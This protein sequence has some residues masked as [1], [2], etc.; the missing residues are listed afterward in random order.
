MDILELVPVF[1]DVFGEEAEAAFFA[2]GRVNLIGEHLDYNGG[3]VF[4]CALTLGT[5][6]LLRRRSDQTVRCYSKNFP[7]AGVKTFSLSDNRYQ[8]G[9][10]WANVVLGLLV[11]LP[12]VEGELTGFDLFIWGNLPHQA[13]LSSSAALELLVGT[14]LNETFHLGLDRL[15]LVKLGQR[16][17][18]HFLGVNSGIMDQF[19]V[20]FGQKDQALYLD[21]ASLAYELVPTHFA[22]YRLLIMDSHK[23][24]EL[25][26]SAYNDRREECEGALKALQEVVD[27][28]HLCE[29]TP[30]EFR[31]HQAVIPTGVMRQRARH[32]VMEEARTQ[33]AKKA[34]VAGDLARFGEL[35]NESHISLRDDYDITGPELDCLVDE[36]QRHFGVL[37]ARMTGA[38]MGGCA[39]ALIH[40]DDTP[41]VT[42]DVRAAFVAKFDREPSFYIAEVG[43]GARALPL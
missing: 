35:L 27:I 24:R 43:A 16:V 8:E 22:P 25:A 21:T 36:A 34:L 10:G 32:V 7:A 30:S 37:G 2:P 42:A 18:N 15:A 40:E 41:E 33:E 6:G 1:K 12:E 38:G 11:C 4:P 28:D 23:Q 17:E 31:E 5:Y 39:L 20:A 29:L 9:L 3:H 26:Q 13:G 19:A 14:A